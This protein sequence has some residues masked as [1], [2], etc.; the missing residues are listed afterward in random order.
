MDSLQVCGLYLTSNDV[1]GIYSAFPHSCRFCRKFSRGTT[2]AYDRRQRFSVGRRA[3]IEFKG[4]DFERGVILWGVHCYV[5]YPIS[6]R[7]PTV[8][9]HVGMTTAISF[10]RSGDVRIG[11]M[12]RLPTLGMVSR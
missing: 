11:Q 8:A 12:L 3:T 6:Y 9:D 7:Q 2:T 1:I 4:S 10:R 5:A